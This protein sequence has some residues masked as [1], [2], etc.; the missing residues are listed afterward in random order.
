MSKLNADAQP[1]EPAAA[2]TSK[3]NADAQPF[4]VGTTGV[5]QQHADKDEKSLFMTFSTGS[6]PTKKEIE[7]YFTR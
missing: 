3:L 4:T 1:F 2:A 7:Q 5:E 6:P